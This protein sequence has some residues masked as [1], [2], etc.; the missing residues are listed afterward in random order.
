[1]GEVTAVNRGWGRMLRWP[2]L[3]LIVLLGRTAWYL[4][5]GLLLL[6]LL[7]GVGIGLFQRT[8]DVLF[9][10][11]LSPF[12]VLTGYWLYLDV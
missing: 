5:G 12:H 2:L 8:L 7:G 9:L 10:S 3:A 4:A 6:G 1:M 11:P